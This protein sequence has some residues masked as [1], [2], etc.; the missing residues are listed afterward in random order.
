MATELFQQ[1]TGTRF[2]Y[3]PY[4]ANPPAV[5]D[6]V[7]GQTDLMI[8]DLATTLPQVKAGKLRALGVTSPQRLPLVQGVPPIAESLRG[9]EFGYWNALYAPAATPAPIVTRLN[10][11]MQGAMKTPAV[12]NAAEQAGMEVALSTPDELARFQQ[13]FVRAGV[14]P[15]VAALHDL[16]G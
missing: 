15:C 9:Y 11:L 1:M 10:A 3:V 14:Q 13:A 2:N 7:A 16:H 12:R 5:M 6:L 8:A 4:K